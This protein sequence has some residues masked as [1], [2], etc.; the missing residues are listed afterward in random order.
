MSARSIYEGITESLMETYDKVQFA[1][2]TLENEFIDKFVEFLG[3]P[4]D[5][6]EKTD[7]NLLLADRQSSKLDL[8]S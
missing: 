7:F 2:I 6:I 4:K 5:A 8:T 3:C 1:Y